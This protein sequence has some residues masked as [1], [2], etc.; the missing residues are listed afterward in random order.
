MLSL[1][2]LADLGLLLLIEQIPESIIGLSHCRAARIRE[3]LMR[4][5]YDSCQP[6]TMTRIWDLSCAAPQEARAL[7]GRL[8]EGL[9]KSAYH[10]RPRRSVDTMALTVGTTHLRILIITTAHYEGCHNF[11]DS[12]P[13]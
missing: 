13:L 8:A 11:E 10:V 7:D 3:A 2:R 12:I 9:S 6:D 1:D 5:V 4:P